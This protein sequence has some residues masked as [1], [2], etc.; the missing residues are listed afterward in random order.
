MSQT[1]L[2][3][4]APTVRRKTPDGK[5]LLKIFQKKLEQGFVCANLGDK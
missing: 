2:F 4:V 5:A 3:F 1:T